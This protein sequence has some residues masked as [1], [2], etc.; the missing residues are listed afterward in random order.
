MIPL[1]VYLFLFIELVFV[2]WI[3]Y[4][5]KK[6]SNYWLFINIFFYLVF[7]F[8][9]PQFYFF[10]IDTFFYPLV[11]LMVGFGLFII[12]IM[13]AGDVKYLFSFFLLIPLKYQDLFFFFLLYSTLIVGLT[14]LSYNTFKNFD[15][16]RKAF[17]LRNITQIREV[18]GKRF[19][20]APV[21]GM[22]WVWFGWS[23]KSHFVY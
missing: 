7:L 14:L 18:Y 9:L 4:K 19:S 20:Y 15:K 12:K 5:T 11:F 23:I 22:A 13:G 10:N 16:I 2:S 17:Q 3:D 1:S 8:V 6:I 21:I